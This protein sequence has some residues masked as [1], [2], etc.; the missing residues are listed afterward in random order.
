MVEY[1]R[2]K[3]MCQAVQRVLS[4][5]QILYPSGL[6]CRTVYPKFRQVFP[7]R[8]H[9]RL[10]YSQLLLGIIHANIRYVKEEMQQSSDGKVYDNKMKPI[11]L[12]HE[13]LI[14]RQPVAY[15]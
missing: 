10:K 1:D 9:N 7:E 4:T 3:F 6:T 13:C 11:D 15:I 8:L 14:F 2:K 12:N 5:D